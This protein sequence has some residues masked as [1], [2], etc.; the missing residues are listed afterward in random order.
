[1]PRCLIFAP[2]LDAEMLDAGRCANETLCQ[3]RVAPCVSPVECRPSELAHSGAVAGKIKRPPPRRC[4]CRVRPAAA[5]PRAA[6]PCTP[7]QLPESP[8][9]SPPR[10]RA[11]PRNPTPRQPRYGQGH[12]RDG[13]GF[14]IA[15]PGG[16]GRTLAEE[17]DFP[18]SSPPSA[19][20]LPPSPARPA[21]PPPRPRPH[22]SSS[23]GGS[24]L[25][26]EGV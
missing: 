10:P 23:G 24:S 14:S 15:N 8:A 1:M 2:C 26:E 17:K 25:A 3:H 6:P 7:P 4:V 18:P 22:P 12:A 9:E 16:L 21:L 19:A 11:H 20:P 13:F 5:A